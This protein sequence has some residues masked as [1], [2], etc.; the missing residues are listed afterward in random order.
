MNPVYDE[1]VIELRRVAELLREAKDTREALDAI[2]SHDEAVVWLDEAVINGKN[3]ET[4]KA[5]HTA[6]IYE[7]AGIVETRRE[8][9]AATRDVE[10]LDTEERIARYALRRALAADE[11]LVD[12][13]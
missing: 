9:R 8:L 6:Y 4:R 2:L 1:A 5:M 3:A 12:L 10:R 13:R 11:S 7:N